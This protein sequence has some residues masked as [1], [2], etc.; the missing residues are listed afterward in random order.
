MGG[1]QSKWDD[2]PWSNIINLEATESYREGS[3][4]GG[5]L[6]AVR[7]ENDDQSIVKA[8]ETIIMSPFWSV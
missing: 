2:D 4:W 8:A 6:R 3:L 7:E 5:E 1:D